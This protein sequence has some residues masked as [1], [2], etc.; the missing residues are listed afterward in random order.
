MT[1]ITQ[2]TFHSEHI[3]CF[4]TYLPSWV[5]PSGGCV[6]VRFEDPSWN[7]GCTDLSVRIRDQAVATFFHQFSCS[8]VSDS[9]RPQG[10]QHARLPCPSPIPGVYSNSCPLSWWCHPLSVPFSSCLQSFLA[11][12]S[13]PVSQF[14]ER[15]FNFQ[16]NIQMQ[17]Q[18]ANGLISTPKSWI[19]LRD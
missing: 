6:C 10:L 2:R 8:V 12:G 3:S 15:P 18:V 17:S 11:S 19:W 1:P 16:E 13:F 9:F 7:K 5:K 4:L 14:W